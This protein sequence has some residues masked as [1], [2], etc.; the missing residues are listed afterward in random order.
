MIREVFQLSGTISIAIERLNSVDSMGEIVTA[1][2]F[3]ILTEMLSRPDALLVSSD[4]IISRTL[5][6]VHHRLSGQ[7]L[8]STEETSSAV[9]GGIFL[10]NFFP[11]VSL[12]RVAF[13]VGVEILTPSLLIRVGIDVSLFFRP[14]IIF[15]EFLSH[16]RS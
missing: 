1:V 5:S 3:S 6:S 10:L 4:R 13:S 16:G 2:S 12:S 8:G 14:F 11:N 7:L 9:R 15:Q